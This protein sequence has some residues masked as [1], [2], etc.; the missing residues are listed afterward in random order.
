[1]VLDLQEVQRQRGLSD[2]GLFAVAFATSLCE[3]E[4]PGAINYIQ[5]AFRSHLT[6][7]L[8]QQKMTAFPRQVRS[9]KKQNR[10]EEQEIVPVSCV[11]RLPE[12]ARM[13][14]CA[15][16]KE[17]YTTESVWLQRDRSRGIVPSAFD[18]ISLC[19]YSLWFEK[20]R[21]TLY[22]HWSLLNFMKIN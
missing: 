4:D 8:E 21:F 2:C 14:V 15:G 17:R 19:L 13:T 9:R 11:C 12:T 22:H 3:G 1:M 18:C 20:E 6:E 7:C 16:C 5:H 10:I